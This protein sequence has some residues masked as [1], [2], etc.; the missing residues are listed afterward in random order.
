MTA[1]RIAPV[2]CEHAR[3]RRTV[4]H[5]KIYKQRGAPVDETLDATPVSW[6]DGAR[7]RLLISD[8]LPDGQQL[9]EILTVATMYRAFAAQ[10][11]IPHR[12]VCEVAQRRTKKKPTKGVGA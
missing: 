10:L 5:V 9:V 4:L 12:E 8:H 2:P 11:Y 6:E 7:I 3:C 1:L